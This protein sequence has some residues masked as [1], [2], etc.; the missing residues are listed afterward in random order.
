MEMP[1][2]GCDSSSFGNIYATTWTES[3][4]KSK[5]TASVSTIATKSWK[6]ID[7]SKTCVNTTASVSCTSGEGTEHDGDDEKSSRF[8]SGDQ[9]LFSRDQS[10][11]T[12][13]GIDGASTLYTED[14]SVN[15][16]NSTL[17]THELGLSTMAADA[18]N[19]FSLFLGLTSSQQQNSRSMSMDADDIESTGVSEILDADE[20][21]EDE[22][23]NVVPTA[24]FVVGKPTDR[25]V[26]SFSDASTGPSSCTDDYHTGRSTSGRS[27][28]MTRDDDDDASTSDSNSCSSSS[29]SFCS[30]DSCSSGYS[31]DGTWEDAPECGTLTNVKPKLSER[32]S[33]VTPD[34]T[35][36]LLRSRFRKKHFPRGTLPY[37]KQDGE[38]STLLGC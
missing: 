26:S 10:E 27:S 22:D 28:R 2:E 36:H 17:F 38:K 37:D 30:S 19:T 23:D 25:Y 3:R 35:S 5:T 18:S 14:Q 33:R 8:G 29:S 34:H 1:Q 32:V 9:S 4:D 16:G 6:S 15:D 11:T 24:S 21:S 12:R 13:T 31:D 7:E 20:P